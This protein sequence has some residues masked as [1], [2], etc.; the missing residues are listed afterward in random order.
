MNLINIKNL[1]RNIN[2]Y[3]KGLKYY[4]QGRAQLIDEYLDE[5]TNLEHYRVTVSGN[6]LYDVEIICDA[7][8]EMVKC[9]CDCIAFHGDR[10]PC[11]H[12]IAALL[13]I[14]AENSRGRD[15]ARLKNG[16]KEDNKSILSDRN[17]LRLIDLYAHK[18]ILALETSFK[19]RKSVV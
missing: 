5:F 2:T 16:E 4:T 10:G 8:G 18:N 19:D 12:I 13:E 6:E 9:T 3:E 14:N 11:K 17:A 15:A 7:F 1:S